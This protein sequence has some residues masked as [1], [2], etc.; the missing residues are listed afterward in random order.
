[1]IT[2]IPFDELQFVLLNAD[3]DVSG[4]HSSEPEL[5]E[6]L[7]EDAL[8]N[9]NNL[10]SVT[11]LVFWNGNLG[12]YFTLVND[13]I[14]VRAVEE[15]DREKSYHFR[16]YP[17]LKIARLATHNSCERFGVGRSMLRKIFSISIT[18]SHYV[19]CRIITVDSKHSAVDFYKKFAFKQAIRMPGETVPLY[20]DLKNALQQ[21][22]RES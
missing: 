14:E 21:I 6:F 3:H 1:M 17:A 13:S 5:D 11:R 15:C 19:G 4:F 9:Q 22:S 18:L 2:P 16:K 12:G 20:L 10:I 7:K 8:V